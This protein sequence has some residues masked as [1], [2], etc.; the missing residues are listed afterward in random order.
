[1]AGGNFVR[2][3]LPAA[4][5]ALLVF[6]FAVLALAIY[7]WTTPKAPRQSLTTSVTAS[8]VTEAPSGAIVPLAFPSAQNSVSQLLATSP[9]A[10][11]RSR[12]S[13]IQPTQQRTSP[14]TYRP[15]LL[16][17]F[18]SGTDQYALVTWNPGQTPNRHRLG[19]ETHWGKLMA[20]E[21]AGVRFDHSGEERILGLF[22]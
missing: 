19:D 2:T 17:I 22:E 3:A 8:K 20:I 14:P 15:K 16:G 12:Y 18:G 4:P 1:M 21:P 6:T 10:P 11:D 9:F 13:R 5:I 7:I